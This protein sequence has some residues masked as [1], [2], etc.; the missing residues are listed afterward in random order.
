MCALRN[1]VKLMHS[2]PWKPFQNKLLAVR[3]STTDNA[4]GQGAVE[5]VSLGTALLR[6][7]HPAGGNLKAAVSCKQKEVLKTPFPV[8]E[9]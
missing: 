6:A 5:G 1:V 9:W 4:S 7:A 3:C 8:V 2:D